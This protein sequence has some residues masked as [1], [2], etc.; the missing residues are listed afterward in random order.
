MHPITVPHDLEPQALAI[1]VH[2][3]GPAPSSLGLSR[4][5]A[6]ALEK[7]AK[8][9]LLKDIIS[10]VL[11]GERF[12]SP[13]LE[14]GW[15]TAYRILWERPCFGTLGSAC[16]RGKWVPVVSVWSESAPVKFWSYWP[17][18]ITSCQGCCYSIC[19]RF[20]LQMISYF[21]LED[22][23]PLNPSCLS[24]CKKKKKIHKK[25]LPRLSLCCRCAWNCDCGRLPLY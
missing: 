8:Q 15:Q 21:V 20:V 6:G 24:F 5:W 14:T 23:E 1:I 17:F 25:I 22:P 18:P 2:L 3:K 10:G 13:S 7:T 11:P 16:S 4:C 19:V 12:L 9:I